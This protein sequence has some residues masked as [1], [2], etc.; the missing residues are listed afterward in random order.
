MRSGVGFS[1]WPAAENAK[2][3]DPAHLLYKVRVKEGSSAI[4]A[5]MEALNEPNKGD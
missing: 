2:F 4:E 3:L 1:Q 5:W